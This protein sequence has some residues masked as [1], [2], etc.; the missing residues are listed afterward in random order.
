MDQRGPPFYCKAKE[1]SMR[2]KK[3]QLSGKSG[4]A[5]AEVMI[6][7]VVMILAFV[8]MLMTYVRCMELNEMSRNKSLATRAAK[9]RME[10]IN[11]SLFSQL[12]VNFQGTP[13]FEAGINGA[14]VSYIDATDPELVQITVT[15][16]WAQKNGRVV[17]EDADLDG[18]LDAGE[19]ANGNGMLDSSVQLVTVRYDE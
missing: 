2:I 4:F 5:L 12:S 10:Q 9:S 1:V 19:D 17:G 3:S 11:N 18:V 15:F 7:A 16:C 6:A 14:G 8:G 13:F